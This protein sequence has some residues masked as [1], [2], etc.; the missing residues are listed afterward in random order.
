MMFN[1][2]LFMN[3]AQTTPPNFYVIGDVQG[4]AN[5]LERLLGQIPTDADVW[6]CGD[7]INRGPDNLDVLRQV[8]ALGAR[9]RVVLGNHDIHLLGVA[10][11]VR[12][13]GRL[14]TIADILDSPERDEWLDWLRQ[15]PLAHYEHGILMVH[16]GV[17]PQWSLAQVLKYSNEVH[18]TLSAPDY[19]EQLTNLFGAST[20]RWTNT[21]KGIERTRAIINALTR[22]RVCDAQGVM[23]FQFKSELPNVPE[24]LLPWFRAPAR[25]TADQPIVYGHWSALGLHYEHNTLCLDTGC[26][27]GGEL[28]AYHYPTGEV[29]SVPAKF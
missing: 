22:I 25:K 9:A 21:L 26:V 11:G 2:N 13:A 20:G 28:T 15:F 12:E 23:D 6:F 3:T 8:R 19:A 4:C 27:W 16:A 24:G 18:Q 1:Q 7:L 5:A 29:I 14:D 17:L 10:A